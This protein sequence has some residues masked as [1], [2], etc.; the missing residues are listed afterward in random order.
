MK[1]VISQITI[2]IIIFLGNIQLNAQENSSWYKV[3][4]VAK[5]VW[6]IDDN[7]S[8]NMY[9]IEGADSALLVDTG[10]GVADLVSVAKKITDKP[11]IVV[12]THGH[13]DHSGANYQFEK[14][15]LHKDDIDAARMFASEEQR[16]RNSASMLQGEK[17]KAQDIYNGK[18]YTTQLL[19]ISEGYIFDLGDRK[20]EVMET[21]GHTP[22]SICFLDRKN[23]ML[24]SGDNNNSLVWLFL[25]G[26]S[27]LSEYLRTLEMQATRLN[28]FTT[29]Y[30]G[31]GP[32]VESTFIN[33]QIICVKAI[34]DGSCKSEPY[35]SFAGDAKICTFK[36]SS[37]AFNPDN[38]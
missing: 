21:P 36:K 8:D 14:V 5:N 30:P 22:G 23:K 7:G 38:L 10:L 27:P 35:Q 37:V 28:E 29:L 11:L 3:S 19:P 33:E 34:L 15:Y 6:L 2:V 24:F 20:I 32:A 26:C 25:Q 18:I 31:H 13:P 4:E 17:P 12:N 9:L 1:F 16:I